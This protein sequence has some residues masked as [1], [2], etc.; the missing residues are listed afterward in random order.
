MGR[1]C[2]RCRDMNRLLYLPFMATCSPAPVG[3]TGMGGGRNLDGKYSMKLVRGGVQQAGSLHFTTCSM[4]WDCLT[5]V[6]S[7][8]GVMVLPKMIATFINA[9][10]SKMYYCRAHY[11]GNADIGIILAFHSK[12]LIPKEKLQ[13]TVNA[14]IFGH[15]NVRTIFMFGRLILGHFTYLVH[16]MPNLTEH[17]CPKINLVRK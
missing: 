4:Y 2:C 9:A 3:S 11:G 10:I 5:C 1:V 14:L 7:H 13:T 12:I 6:A 15:T 8:S 16:F 17:L